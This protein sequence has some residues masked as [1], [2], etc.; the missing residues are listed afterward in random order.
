MIS[1][2]DNTIQVAVD[3]NCMLTCFGASVTAKS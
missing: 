2:I 1:A 3:A